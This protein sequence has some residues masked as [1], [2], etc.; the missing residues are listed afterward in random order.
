MENGLN[1]VLASA[2]GVW[3][4]LVGLVIA[5]SFSVLGAVVLVI[6]GYIFAGYVERAVHLGL[7]RIRGFD[8]TLR[9]FLSKLVR[10]AIMVMLAVTVLAQFGVQT[11]SILAALGAAGLA[12]GLAL[13]AAGI[14]LLWLWPFRVGEE[15]AT[16]DVKGVVQEVGLFATRMR[17]GDGLYMLCPNS[18]LWNTPI[19]N[20]S[21]NR[22]RKAAIVIPI[23]PDEDVDKVVRLLEQV[24]ENDPRIL[25]DPR[26][27]VVIGEIGDYAT[28]LKI[29]F[30]T[31]TADNGGA[32]DAITLQ[33]KLA[34]VQA[35]I[36]PPFRD[37]ASI[38][39]EAPE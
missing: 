27:G 14:M 38:R 20:F 10:Y 32:K 33:S 36:R 13:Q 24:V 16:K 3:D 31:T 26:P 2:D 23:G 7:S 19:T 1:A 21:R 37:P 17:T 34:L 29:G 8:E 39:R 25:N 28:K 18:S 11:A 6:I 5:Y 9:V 4:A 35:G 22:Q 30:W 12:I 15:I